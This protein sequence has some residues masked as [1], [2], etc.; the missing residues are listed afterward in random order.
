MMQNYPITFWKKLGLITLIVIHSNLYSQ[1]IES[2]TTITPAQTQSLI[3]DYQGEGA[4]ASAI[5]GFFFLDIDTDQ[6]GLPDFYETAPSDD[7]DGDGLPN[8]SDPDDDN[9]GI[10]DI[11]DTQPAG[12]TSMPASFFRNGTV[13]QTNGNTS[14]D[15]WQFIPNSV[16]G[17]GKYEHPGVYLYI[18]NNG[19]SIPDILEY[20]T[21]SNKMPPY[22]VDKG[23]NTTHALLGSFD[24]LLG[25]WTYSGSPSGIEHITGR[26]IFY[27]CDDD[28]G[29]SQTLNYTSHS[30]YSV[31]DIYSN[32]NGQVDYNIYDTTDSQSTKIPQAILGTDL[33]GEDFYKYRWFDDIVV[34]PNRELV[35][36]TSVFW[37]SGGSSVNTYYSKTGFNSDNVSSF[38][39]R[40][41]STT[42]DNFGGSS[43]SNWYPDYRSTE[44]HDLIAPFA[45]M[46]GAN[47]AAIASSPV[48]GTSPIAINPANQAWVDM[49]ENWTESRRIVQYR[50]VNDWFSGTASDV[51]TLINN[52]YTYD[53]TGNSQ[54]VIVRAKEGKMAHLMVISPDEDPN[55]FIIG[56][57]DLFGGGDRDFE[58]NVFYV[59]FHDNTTVTGTK[60]D[61]FTVNQC[62]GDLQ[63]EVEITNV[64]AATANGVTFTDTPDANT[65]L[66]VGTVTT[67][68]GSVVSGNTAGDTDIEVN[69]GSIAAGNTVTIT[70]DV[71]VNNGVFPTTTTI[72][73]QGTVSGSNFTDVLTGD[74]DADQHFEITETDLSEMIDNTAPTIT[75]PAD[76]DVNFD[77]NCQYELLDYTTM[78]TTGDNCSS[79]VTVTQN[80]T[81]GTMVTS[82]TLITLTA[83]D[84]NGNT[85]TCSFTVKITDNT[86]PVA[87]CVLPFTI[88][89][90]A[91]GNASI[92]VADIND[93]STDNCS[94]ASMSLD[95]TSFDCNNLGPNTILLTVTDTSGN[96]HSCST[97][98]TV[99]DSVNPVANCVAPFT[100]QLDGTGNASITAAG[101][102]DSSTDNCSIDTISIDETSFDCSD[103]GANTVT[104]TI[105]DASGN[106][107]TC[108][109]TVTVEDSVNPVANCVAPF[110]IQLDATGNASIT[111]VDIDD[112]STD[113]C[114]ID[115]ISIDETS[116]DCSDLGANTITLTVTDA[117]G[118]SNTCTTTVTVEDSINPV[119]NCVAPF[120][121]Q[122]DGTGN[123]SITAVDIDDSSTDN[124][125]I[126]S[127]SLDDTSFDC[128]DLGVNMVTLTV[129]DTSGN[130]NTCT[131]TVTVVDT[132]DPVANCV[133]PFIVQL[134]NMGNASITSAMVDAGSSDNCSID[135][136]SIDETSFDC[137]DLGANTVILTV[138]D[139]SGNSD[140]CTTIV[141]VEDS[142]N[143]I[144]NCVAPFTVQLDG[145]GSASIT[146]ADIDDSSTDN[147]SIDSI[148]IDE[149]SFDCTHLGVNTVMLTVIDASG[150]ADT[151]TTT[152][153]VVDSVNPVATCVAPFTIQL[154]ATGNASITAADIN[155]GS[156]DNC[157]IDS[158]IIDETSFDCTDLGVNTVTLT[159]T[160]A[161]GNS[162]TCTTAVTVE[163]SVNPVANCVVPFTIQLDATGNASITAGD[164]NDGSTDN[165]GIASTSI[166]ITS[167]DCSTVGVNT[168]TLIVTDAS[169][170]SD[171][172]TTTVTVEDSV[173]PIANCVA[174]FTVQLDATGNASITAADIDDSSIDNCGVAS[175]SIDISSFDCTNLGMNVVTL[176]VTDTSGNIDTCTTTVTVEDNILP[177]ANCVAPFTIEL[178]PLG[179]AVLDANTVDDN[180]TDNCGIVDRTIDKSIFNLSDVGDHTIT[181]TVTD[182][183][184]NT[185][186]CSTIITIVDITPPEITLL[187]DNPQVIVLGD[188]YTELGATTIDGSPITIDASNF[189]D[190]TGDYTVIYSATD[191][192]GNRSEVTRTVQVR[193]PID[194]YF[195]IYPNPASSYFTIIGFD[196]LKALEIY[197]I[198]GRKIRS[199][200][201]ESLTRSISVEDFQEGVYWLKGYFFPKESLLRKVVIK[202]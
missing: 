116:F 20:T 44:D 32:I 15:Y 192:S 82:D 170:N 140:T 197:D 37:N 71:T 42:G 175:T 73:N 120:T 117:S 137:S 19:N 128:N 29:S 12:V 56:L 169:G 199:Y 63:Y 79:T 49:H 109:T 166:D 189:V 105:I 141:T 110:T 158:I 81:A 125:S 28:N 17:S 84:G 25:D 123:A 87:A 160:D 48:D 89:L 164:I 198:G 67:S 134:D 50:A 92:T 193:D 75:C 66:T 135:T 191:A 9:D 111:A 41:G 5:L 76:Q 70:F 65:T 190:A 8:S 178:S 4:G 183:A 177:V 150:N 179:V 102:D 86:P 200:I 91:T 101:I 147:C 26:T 130:S 7:L 152:V 122:L 100:V 21:G 146:A 108:T 13:A 167:F 72:S 126:A 58:D 24:G 85:N 43:Q 154:D 57:E 94:I 10:P 39:N 40:N 157:S 131:T 138:T 201:G 129:T 195:E 61:I 62:T 171:T 176:T 68:A 23:V 90:D 103:L 95:A 54:N 187:G 149:T 180:S 16:L 106:S 133:S 118:N 151:C 46:P 186:S 172:C 97:T 47:W 2:I 99:E 115:S 168:V 60:K 3:V 74:P 114:G 1:S 96:S 132:I 181:L 136:I 104:L 156:T 93:G 14:G 159:V 127:M 121:I 55:S 77:T 162:D 45:P 30:P 153:T 59:T 36:F 119:A 22:A 145:T 88:Q 148:T 51:N 113:N 124:C 11:S 143:P 112:S 69:V 173:N 78:A 139:A 185:T 6:D 165:C 53:I 161:S 202:H 194:V 196:N 31:T 80:P 142:I 174:P 52:R 98:V 144:A 33:V 182:M 107:D 155:N 18:D 188:G 27:I 38:V 184:G 163:D 64:G 35:F 83:D 34:S